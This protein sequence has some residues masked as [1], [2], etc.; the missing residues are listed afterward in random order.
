MM[1]AHHMSPTGPFQILRTLN[2][3]QSIS[4]LQVSMMQFR[5]FNLRQVLMRV[6]AV[7]GEGTD[8]FLRFLDR[9]LGLTVIQSHLRRNELAGL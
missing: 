4:K 1:K 6:V 7:M 5:L 9:E 8:G 2:A 3:I